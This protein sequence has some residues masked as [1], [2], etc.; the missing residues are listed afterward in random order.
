NKWKPRAIVVE[1]VVRRA[2][3]PVRPGPVL[4]AR[5]KEV[6]LADPPTAPRAETA[7]A[8]A[9]DR[10]P[11]RQP[12]RAPR[13]AVRL[14]RGALGTRLRPRLVFAPLHKPGR[15]RG[16]ENQAPAE[17]NCRP[18]PPPAAGPLRLPAPAQRPGVVAGRADAGDLDR[19]RRAQGPG[20]LA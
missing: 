18:E 5:H 15:A 12:R 3:H 13:P 2:G 8:R 9:R 7:D 20:L 14:R 17:G 16:G 4:P 10:R 11:E 19:L 6:T 1:W